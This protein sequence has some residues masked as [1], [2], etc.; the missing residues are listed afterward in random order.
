MIIAAAAGS[1]VGI[2]I[3]ESFHAVLFCGGGLMVFPLWVLAKR[4]ERLTRCDE[5]LPQALQI[6]ILALRAGHALPGALALG[7]REAPK[8]IRDELRRAVDEH[9]L[10]RPLGQV[11]ANLATRLPTSDTA[12]TFAVAV[13]V[14]EQTGG[15]LIQVLDRL[16]ENARAR[17]Q[18]RAKLKALT[19]QGRWSAW[20]LCGM[21]FGF[22][23]VASIVDP[24]YLPSLMEHKMLFVLFFAL[25]VPG[26]MWTVRMVNQAKR[27]S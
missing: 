11:I 21:P 9:G 14:L 13:L 10:G 3:G 16:V 25:W 12:Q 20:I 15:N 7:A 27:V 6:M 8:P 26:V 5:Q 19:T 23:A 4:S 24:G 22:G 18:Y 1:L 2:V 17:T